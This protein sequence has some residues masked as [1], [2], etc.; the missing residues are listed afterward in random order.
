[1]EIGMMIFAGC[2]R[3]GWFMK[4]FLFFLCLVFRMFFKS[5]VLSLYKVLITIFTEFEF[6]FSPLFIYR[7]L[8]IGEQK[9]RRQGR[10]HSL[11]KIIKRKEVVF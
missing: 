9:D 3:F 4:L 1:M 7:R 8:N 5:G 2:E 6:S 10:F 11:T